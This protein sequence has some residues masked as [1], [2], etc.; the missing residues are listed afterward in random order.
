MW[1]Q[2][3]QQF[4]SGL[5]NQGIDPNSAAGQQ[6]FGNFNRGRNDAYQGAIN[7][8]SMFGGQEASRQQGMDLSLGWLLWRAWPDCRA[9]GNAAKPAASGGLGAVPG[10]APEVR[11][12]AA[13]KELHSAA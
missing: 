7:N 2:R 8:A 10:G 5:T 13:G 1:Q 3:E 9:L 12:R 11:N 4:N 6:A